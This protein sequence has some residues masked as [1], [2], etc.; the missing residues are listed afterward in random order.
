MEKG[1]RVENGAVTSEK[2]KLKLRQKGLLL[3]YCGFRDSS[4][5]VYP[6]LNI[7]VG[8][9][10]EWFEEPCIYNRMRTGE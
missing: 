4:T 7:W 1:G 9:S 2:R 3:L 10:S 6:H 8:L 5:P